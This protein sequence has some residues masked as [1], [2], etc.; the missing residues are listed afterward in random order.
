[1]N[2]ST[3]CEC[4]MVR[5]SQKIRVCSV[6][7]CQQDMSTSVSR[8]ERVSKYEGVNK[9]T[10]VICKIQFHVPCIYAHASVRGTLGDSRLC[11]CVRVTSFE[12]WLTPFVCELAD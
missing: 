3:R 6:Q 10:H 1:M 8:C 12:C 2:V 9:I 5:T 7:A 11:S 4:V